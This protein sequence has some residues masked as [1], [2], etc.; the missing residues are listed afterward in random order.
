V[1]RRAAHLY[2]RLSGIEQKERAAR[3]TIDFKNALSGL[4]ALLALWASVGSAQTVSADVPEYLALARELVE[5]TAPEN[6]RYSLGGQFIS[7][8]GDL[9]SSKYSVRADCSGF[10]LAILERAKYSTRSRME[11]LPGTFRRR[12]RP[13]AEDFVYSIEME[14]GFKRI[15]DARSIQPGDLLAHAMLNI[16]DQRQTGTT[17]HVFLIDS[18]PKPIEPRTPIVA[19]T[20]QFAI[21]V[22]DS[23]EE[24]VGSDDSRL[25]DPS[26]KI[27]GL[28]RGTIRIYVDTNGEIV[29]WARTFKNVKKFFSYDSRFPSDTKPRKAAIGRPIAGS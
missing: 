28:G 29:G 8:P 21:S 27:R 22:I 3:V 23:N 12:T 26:N 9:F 1:P 5:N 4:M 11:Y 16:E 14:K 13:A 17:G 15:R 7:F 6:N 2:V 10:L 19:G 25:A 24:Y 20:Q 18:V